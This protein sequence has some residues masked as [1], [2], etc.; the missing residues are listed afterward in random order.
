MPPPTNFIETA[1]KARDVY[2]L[3]SR[4]TRTKLLVV[5]LVGAITVSYGI[6]AIDVDKALTL[7]LFQLFVWTAI[8]YI[9]SQG[10][11]DTADK[12]STAWGHYV[13]RKYPPPPMDTTGGA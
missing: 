13:D 2:S 7:N 12:I 9:I 8:A 10:L 11:V 5:L 1:Q 6:N 4:L 3:V